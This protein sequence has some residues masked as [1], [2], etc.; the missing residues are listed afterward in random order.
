MSQPI[1]RHYF[2]YVGYG[3]Q[4]HYLYT[5][6][7]SQYLR[8]LT[9]NLCV[10]LGMD[11]GRGLEAYGQ[12]VSHAVEVG[13]LFE[14]IGLA[15]P[16]L[17]K[18]EFNASSVW[19]GSTTSAITAVPKPHDG[20]G[21]EASIYKS[22]VSM[23]ITSC[24]GIMFSS[25][26]M[27]MLTVLVLNILHSNLEH[28]A[29][30]IHQQAVV[31][32]RLDDRLGQK[33]VYPYLKSL[34][35]DVLGAYSDTDSS[36]TARIAMPAGASFPAVEFIDCGSFYPFPDGILW[37]GAEKVLR[38]L[39]IAIDVGCARWLFPDNSNTTELLPGPLAK[40]TMLASLE[41]RVITR[42]DISDM[43]TKAIH[44]RVL[45]ASFGIPQL[46]KLCLCYPNAHIAEY[47]K[48]ANVFR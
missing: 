31:L 24:P 6:L 30:L 36:N 32:E 43:T 38:K 28:C 39:I 47:K 29:A 27:P 45:T 25:S 34:R 37:Y 14:A 8:R 1:S 23:D 2:L 35:L 5:A 15:F 4:Q 44:E 41:V 33:I 7:V 13:S 18:V 22:I 20:P 3:E 46:D 11:F 40:C 17:R 9:K 26:L 10:V 19:I 16:V 48:E 12:H 42:T 21:K